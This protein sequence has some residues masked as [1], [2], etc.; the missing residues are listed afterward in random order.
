MTKMPCNF[1]TII[2]NSGH[3]DRRGGSKLV[4]MM[5]GGNAILGVAEM[6]VAGIQAEVT[7]SSGWSKS[8]SKVHFIQSHR[9]IWAHLVYPTLREKCF[10]GDIDRVIVS[11]LC[12]AS[13]C[14]LN[15]TMKTRRNKRVGIMFTRYTE[16]WAELAK[17][18]VIN[19]ISY[20][21]P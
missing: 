7:I 11:E 15:L 13:Y 19:L 2:W 21:E 20:W 18:S 3:S 1:W 8:K 4:K 12:L 5:L 6:C 17:L 16:R 10:I 9:E 14:K